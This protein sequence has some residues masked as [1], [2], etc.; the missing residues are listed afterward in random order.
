MI[1]ISL[2]NQNL[3]PRKMTK[4]SEIAALYEKEVH[5]SWKVFSCRIP[6]TLAPSILSIIS[7]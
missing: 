4:E 7:H 6:P 1:I 3:C 2:R 5:R